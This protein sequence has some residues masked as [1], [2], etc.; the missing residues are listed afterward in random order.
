ML[1]NNQPTIFGKGEQTRDYVYVRDIVTSN[2]IVMEKGDNQAFN[3]GTGKETTVNELYAMVKKL[4]GYKEDAN[5]S[6]SR[7]GELMR[8]CLNISK[9]KELLNWQP[10]FSLEQGLKQTVDWYQ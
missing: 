1:S 9:A 10:Q 6:E 7:P 4:T 3:L 5:Y 2:L 8:N